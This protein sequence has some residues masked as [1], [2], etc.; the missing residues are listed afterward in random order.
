MQ[1]IS[2]ETS[3]AWYAM[4][5][6]WYVCQHLLL[7][8]ECCGFVVIDP[9][10]SRMRQMF[11]ARYLMLHRNTAVR[12]IVLCMQWHSCSR[13]LWRMSRVQG[14]DRHGRSELGASKT[15]RYAIVVV[16]ADETTSPRAA[17]GRYVTRWSAQHC[18]PVSSRLYTRCEIDSLRGNLQLWGPNCS[19]SIFCGLWYSLL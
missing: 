5:G 10:Q 4:G 18:R 13:E 15:H 11:G 7:T 6:L 9:P 2:H 8:I 3:R 1:V 17:R 16:E 14:G 12:S 19:Y